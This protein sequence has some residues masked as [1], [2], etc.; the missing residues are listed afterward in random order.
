MTTTAP[1]G[2]PFG[3]EH[4]ILLK[5]GSTVHLRPIRPDD[6]PGLADLVSRMS[7]E[8]IYHRFFRA[9][10]GLTD[11][12]L[13]AFTV[14]D[15]RDRMAFVVETDAHL[16]GVGRYARDE[17]GGDQAE[18]AFSVADEYQGRG[19]ATRVLEYLTAY[20]RTQGITAFEAY[21]LADNHAMIRVFRGAGFTMTRQ[22]DEGVYRIEFPTDESDETRAAAEEHEKRAAAAS[23]TPV[24][25]PTSV[26]VIGAS[27]DPDSIGGRLLANLLAGDFTGPVYPVNP[28]ATVVRSMR[29]YPSVLDIDDRVDLAVIVVPA[30]YVMESVRQCAEKGVKGLVV[31]SAGFSET[32]PEGRD[33]E[34]RAGRPGASAQHADDRPQLHGGGEHR[35]GGE[36]QRPVRPGGGPSGQRRHV[37]AERGT[38]NRHPRPRHPDQRRHLELRLGG[39]QGGRVGQRPAPLL[40]GRPVDRRHP[41][42]PRVLREPAAVRPDRPPH[43]QEEAD[44]GG[45]VGE[46]NGRGAGGRVTHRVAGQPRR[47]RRRPVPAGRGHPHRHPCRAV[48]RYRGAGQSTAAPGAPGGGGQQRRGPR[49]SRRRHPGIVGAGGA[50]ALR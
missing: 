30:P 39:Q 14:L 41:P 18:V 42:L 43:R 4:D 25:Y 50:R 33:L 12:E 10:S 21:V 32:G 24:L 5:D 13:E 37:L 45:E 31:I 48:R 19:V 27:R 47:R 8:S 11:A 7:R 1:S 15:Y 20:A 6:A 17:P 44:R 40:G 46:D 9:R 26:A 49:H 3:W 23:L 22:L 29:A 16:A 35:P 2:Y 36:P 38:G 28:K 34:S